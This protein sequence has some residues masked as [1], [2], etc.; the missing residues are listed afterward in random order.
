VTSKEIFVGAHY[1]I[2][3]KDVTTCVIDDDD[4]DGNANAFE[5]MSPTHRLQGTANNNNNNDYQQWSKCKAFLQRCWN[6]KLDKEERLAKEEAQTEKAK[7]A[8]KRSYG[9]SYSKQNKGSNSNARRVDWLAKN[10]S[11]NTPREIS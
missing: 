3:W 11:A 7:N 10:E 2:K 5:L 4:E 9:T 8:P 6:K 1:K